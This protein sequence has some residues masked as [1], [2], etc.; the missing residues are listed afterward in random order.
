MTEREYHNLADA[1]FARLEDRL[2]CID[3]VDFELGAGGVLEIE[4]ADASRIVVNRQAAAQ[5][6]WVAAKSGGFHFRYVDGAWLARHPQ[7]RGVVRPIEPAGQR[8]GRHAHRPWRLRK[9]WFILFAAEAAP[10]TH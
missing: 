3:A 6:I 10:T 4:F 8:A 9:R 1:L 7:R 2:S 5:E